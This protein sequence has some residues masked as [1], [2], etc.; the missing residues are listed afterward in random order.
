MRPPPSRARCLGSAWWPVRA[1]KTSSSVGRRTAT[2]SATSFASSRRRTAS[3]IAPLP[4]S[5]GMRTVAAV[6][7]RQLARHAAERP[8]RL[9]RLGLVGQVDLEALAADAVLELVGG[10]VGDHLAVVDD[11]DAVGEPV[12]LVEVLG[13][14]QDGRAVGDEVLDRHP[15]VDAAARVEARRRLV[16]EQHR[17]ARD[18]RGREVEP[19]AHAAGV[20]LRDA[21]GGVGEVEALEQL[22]AARLR[23]AAALAV[24]AADHDE[25]LEAGEVVVDRGVLAGEA[26]PGAQ[27]AGVADDVEAGDAGRCRRRGRGGWRGSGPSWSCRRRWG[28]G[29]RG[30]CPERPRGRRRR[31]RG[32]RRTT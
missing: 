21:V 17:R 23:G 7:L 30:R 5:T 26:D 12:G 18:E 15:Q 6:D 24:E 3:M 10:A 16:E 25:V 27:R 14:Q 31:A 29:R 28:R 1:R 13:G 9:E 32:R 20:G 19:A 11:R 8:R 2:S 22:A 4:R